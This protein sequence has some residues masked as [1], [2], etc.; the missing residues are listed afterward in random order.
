MEFEPPRNGQALWF[1]I[2]LIRSDSNSIETCIFVSCC[3]PSLR[4]KVIPKT[5]LI[6]IK[7]W[8][9]SQIKGF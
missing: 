1:E 9:F 4:F 5:R 8:F 7:I 2:Y 6:G 3:V